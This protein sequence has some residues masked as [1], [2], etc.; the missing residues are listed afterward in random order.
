MTLH[1]SEPAS[2]R[3]QLQA[4]LSRLKEQRRAGGLFLEGVAHELATS[5]T[6]LM[7]YLKLLQA[8][9]LG[10]LTPQQQRVV[11]AMAGAVDRLSHAV[12][13]VTDF[14]A[15][16]GADDRLLREPFSLSAMV[17]RVVEQAMPGA[18]AR[19]VRLELRGPTALGI[20]GDETRLMHAFTALLDCAVG[21]SPHGG[22]VLIQLRDDGS[23]VVAELFDQGH[24]PGG[25]P[26]AARPEGRVGLGL[27]LARQVVEAH[28]GE[29][30]I[31]SP[32]K[33]QPEVRELYTGTH[34][35][36]RLPRSSP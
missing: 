18:T 28:G 17:A 16:G 12:E 11:D 21:F 23:T 27:S 33:E 34:A 8:G 30:F 26:P 14:A 9:R 15:I 24:G 20:T 35:G 2:E 31:E 5:V 7:G 22:H 1:P 25:D 19:H 3:D 32:P 6:P 29:L 4:E 36:F 13:E 10:A